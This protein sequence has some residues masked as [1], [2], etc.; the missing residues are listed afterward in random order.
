[1]AASLQDVDEAGKIALDVG[2]RIGERVADAGLRR[3]VDHD[4]RFPLREDPRHP[5][6]VGYVELDEI[7]PALAIEPRHAR[8]LQADVVVVVDIVEA[9][10]L[11]ATGEEAFRH[12]IPDEPRRPRDQI[13]HPASS[14]FP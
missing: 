7:V 9:R 6:I 13:A 2:V 11:V 10:Y 8:M 1:M 4:F 5:L 14:A 3:E 12:V